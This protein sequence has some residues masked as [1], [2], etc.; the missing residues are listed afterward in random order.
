MGAGEVGECEGKR[1]AGVEV[2]R[3]DATGIKETYQF[4][5]SKQ[6]KCTRKD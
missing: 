1:R 4:R 2:S 5:E 3:G 6:P